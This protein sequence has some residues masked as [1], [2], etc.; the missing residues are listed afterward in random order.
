MIEYL[1]QMSAKFQSRKIAYNARGYQI[2]VLTVGFAIIIA[3][4]NIN[5]VGPLVNR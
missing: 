1:Q 5:G 4:I 2:H 3:A